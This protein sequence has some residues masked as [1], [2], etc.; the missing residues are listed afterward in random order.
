MWL[1]VTKR[2]DS[3]ERATVAKLGFG[4]FLPD[5]PAMKTL[6]EVPFDVVHTALGTSSTRFLGAGSFGTVYLTI[7]P[8]LGAVAV[9]AT[10]M[11][12]SASGA[13]ENELHLLRVLHRHPH[14]GVIK[15]LGL[16]RNSEDGFVRLIIEHCRGGSLFARLYVL[17]EAK[18]ARQLNTI[19]DRE[20][21]LKHPLVAQ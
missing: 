19:V 16:C 10:K 4:R 13:I 2:D 3:A 17:S 1:G 12:N 18:Q 15:L 5:A 9:K 20:V 11:Q 6:V 7:L 14:L 21:V 8:K